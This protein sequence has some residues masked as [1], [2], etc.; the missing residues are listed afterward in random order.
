VAVAD[1]GLDRGAWHAAELAFCDPSPRAE[2]LVYRQSSMEATL[3]LKSYWKWAPQ[4][5]LWLMPHIHFDQ[6]LM[7]PRSIAVVDA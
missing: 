6:G 5:C 2:A 3:S 1:I 4:Q 7:I